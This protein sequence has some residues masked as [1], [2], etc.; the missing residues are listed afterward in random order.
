[1]A[2]RH[3]NE[4]IAYASAAECRDVQPRLFS[5]CTQRLDEGLSPDMR[6]SFLDALCKAICDILMPPVLQRA[7]GAIGCM[8]FVWP[9]ILTASLARRCSDV[10][11]GLLFAFHCNAKPPLQDLCHLLIVV[12]C[13]LES[14]GCDQGF[15]C[16]CTAGTQE[17]GATASVG[18]AE[19]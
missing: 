1:V 16:S 19:E 2:H 17:A 6:A 7:T 10:L 11:T 13:L 14:C 8:I 18:S 9:E 5:S 3:V 12:M 15:A 4:Q